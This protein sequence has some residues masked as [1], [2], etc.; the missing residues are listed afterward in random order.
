MAM[1]IDKWVQILAMIIYQV[2]Y[3]DLNEHHK[4]FIHRHFHEFEIYRKRISYEARKAMNFTKLSSKDYQCIFCWYKNRIPVDIVL[5]AIQELNL[6]AKQNNK[7]INSV[8]YFRKA[9]LR[10]ID[11][12]KNSYTCHFKFLPFQKSPDNENGDLWLYQ[13]YLD[14]ENDIYPGM[15]FDPMFGPNENQGWE[16]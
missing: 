14:W 10:G 9:I 2:D 15:K 3:N 11:S 6:Y 1:P 4:Y 12:F 5:K 13:A 8:K 7:Q 16:R